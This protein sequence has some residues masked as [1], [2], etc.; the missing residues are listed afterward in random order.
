MALWAGF[1]LQTPAASLWFAGDTGYG[2]GA[3]FR[4]IRRRHGSPDIALLPIGA[5][6][7]RWFMTPQHVNPA[8]AVRILQDIG[9]K[10]ALG[11]HWGTFQLTD[12][13]IDS[14][15]RALSTALAEAG[16]A[17]DSFIAASPGEAY[18]L[19]EG[20]LRIVPSERGR[21]VDDRRGS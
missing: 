16:I 4:D 3:I 12:E 17:A 19:A 11:I 13:G 7:P 9:A 2:D 1:W 15:P 6:E 21:S 14:P 5:Y 20:Q 18:K 10:A 8:E